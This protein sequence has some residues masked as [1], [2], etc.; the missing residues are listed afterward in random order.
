MNEPDTPADSIAAATHPDPYPYYAGLVANRALY[1]DEA[2]GLW[3]AASAEAVTAVLTHPAC[4]VRPDS[5]PVPKNLLGSPAA[6]IFRH[7]VRTNDGRAHCPFKQA[8]SATLDGL[9]PADLKSRA[10]HWAARLAEEIGPETDP[11]RCTDFAFALPVH[12]TGDLLGLAEERLGEV[13]RWVGE[14]VRCFF[15]GGAPEEIER[16]KGAA[17]ELL[18]IFRAQLAEMGTP[19]EPSLLRSLLS[20]AHSF[21][22]GDR[23]VVIANA[24][25]FLTQGYD[26]TAALIGT[27]L[28]TLARRPE[29]LADV[30]HSPAAL[31]AFVDE[32]LRFD[33][34]VQNTR[35]FLAEAVVLEGH[36][37]RR[38]D[39]VLVLL[40]AANRDPR[41]NP[42]PDRFDPA[43][44]NPQVF[45]FGLGPH[46]C[47]GRTMATTIA[48]AGV[49]RLLS[50]GVDPA[51]L[52]TNPPF[53]PSANVRMPLLIGG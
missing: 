13:A 7:L 50:N 48:R 53:R 36:E 28:L 42:E 35:R 14:L 3:V 25:G 51:G 30:R 32:I 33:S 46:V 19:S 21:G 34:P 27:T 52:E 4:R 12:V 24:I 49:S 31:P 47:P 20:H 40:G 23:D 38:D 10:E 2:L 44:R 6:E 15:P 18:E 17:G 1:F 39:A 26:A 43:R 29:L 8:V 41:A 9:D 22:R 11:R 45:T 16:G 5:E 37:L